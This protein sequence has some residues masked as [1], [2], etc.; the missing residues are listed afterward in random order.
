MHTFTEKL[1][2]TELISL[3]YDVNDHVH[4]STSNLAF[5]AKNKEINI[6]EKFFF[7]H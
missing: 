5:G 1:Q 2:L 3:N 7:H 4:L 6:D